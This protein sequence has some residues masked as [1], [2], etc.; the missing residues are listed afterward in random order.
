MFYSEILRII[1]AG[2]DKDKDKVKNYAQLLAKKLAADGDEKSSKRIESLLT[3]KNNGTAITDALVA[4][5]VDQESR[6][7]ILDINYN[8]DQPE[9]VLSSAIKNRLSDFEDTIR[10]K[11]KLDSIGMQFKMSLLLYGPPGCGKTS[12]AY[13]VANQLGLPLVTARLDTLISSL[14]GNTAKNLRR[15]FD[16]ANRQPCVLFLDE[17]DAIAKARDDQHE[18]GELKRVVNSLL[19]NM[20]TYC[21]H[22]VLIAA[23]N[24]QELLD[25]AIWRRFQ[26][27]I[28]VP[29]PSIKEIELFFSKITTS[30][31]K[32]GIASKHLI[33]IYKQL[34]GLSYSD[35]QVLG[36]NVVKQK[37]IQNKD[38]VSAIDFLTEIMLFKQHANIERYELIHYLLQC[39]IPQRTIAEHYNISVRQ[40][41]NCLELKGDKQ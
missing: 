14:L 23:T 15:V 20:D 38:S 24:H 22:G 37:L 2:L 16:Y 35:I 17:F 18:L 28:E 1:E 25:N 31:N 34:E 9:I 8:P 32:E 39:G 21:Q 19:Q 6:M 11:D 41:R 7:G 30:L 12:I 29:K 33:T 40:V 27:V 10:I 26:T 13:Y 3:K 4:P 36:Q 5:P